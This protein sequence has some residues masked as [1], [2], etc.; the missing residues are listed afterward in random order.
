MSDVLLNPDDILPGEGN[1]QGKPL[2][3]FVQSNGNEK[4]TV[5]AVVSDKHLDLFVQTMYINKKEA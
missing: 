2:I 3:K 4:T 5:T 1:Y